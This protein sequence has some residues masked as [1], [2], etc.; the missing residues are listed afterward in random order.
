VIFKIGNNVLPP[1]INS[2]DIYSAEYTPTLSEVGN[3]TLTITV[4][5]N[6]G[7]AS[8]VTYPIQVTIS[9]G[10]REGNLEIESL[11]FGPNP[12]S[13]FL[14]ISSAPVDVEVLNQN[15]EL[16]LKELNVSSISV[17]SLE[18]GVYFVRINDQQGN[19]TVERL[20]IE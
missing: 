8:S 9:I 1:F 20:I 14:N 15:G 2:G 4:T 17:S 10:A 11:N 19:H 16:M 3:Q 6:K 12:A 7:V 5:D 13:D 18:K